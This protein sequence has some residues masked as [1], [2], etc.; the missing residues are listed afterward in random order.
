MNRRQLVVASALGVVALVAPR[1][2]DD[3]PGAEARNRKRKRRRGGGASA[4]ASASVTG[5]T[6]RA[7]ASV[8]CDNHSQS[9]ADPS[10]TSVDCRS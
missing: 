3:V 2:L 6:G 4:S 8:T 5:N 7:N 10:Q 9:E 1:G